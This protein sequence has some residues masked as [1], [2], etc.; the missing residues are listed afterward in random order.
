MWYARW[1]L[2]FLL[3]ENHLHPCQSSFV[4]K[5]LDVF[6]SMFDPGL[7]RNLEVHDCQ[8]WIVSIN[9]SCNAFYDFIFTYKLVVSLCLCTHFKYSDLIFKFDNLHFL[10]DFHST[11][12]PSH[13]SIQKLVEIDKTFIDFNSHFQ[14]LFLKF[15]SIVEL[16][17]KS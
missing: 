2:H 8:K 14:K 12:F 17:A 3:R 11:I 4:F 5:V 16:F 13:A 6:P 7:N 9:F 15:T 10:V 1:Y